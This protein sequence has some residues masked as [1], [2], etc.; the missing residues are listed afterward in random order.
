V[1]SWELGGRIRCR[2]EG[3]LLEHDGAIRR[4]YMAGASESWTSI[5]LSR[6]KMPFGFDTSTTTAKAAELKALAVRGHS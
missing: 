3:I 6:M 5:S 1:R 4:E 2:D